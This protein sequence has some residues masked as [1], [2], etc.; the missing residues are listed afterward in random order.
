MHY[1]T[2]SSKC[3]RDICTASQ[4]G[5]LDGEN[6]LSLLS[7]R[8]KLTWALTRRKAVKMALSWQAVPMGTMPYRI[9]SCMAHYHPLLMSLSRSSSAAGSLCWSLLLWQPLT[10]GPRTKT[11]FDPRLPFWFHRHT[12]MHLNVF[13]SSTT[14]LLPFRYVGCCWCAFLR[15]QIFISPFFVRPAWSCYGEEW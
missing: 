5:A 6:Q 8:S 1:C 12:S 13:L 15:E 2:S 7:Q 14:R 9:T 10:K 11:K 4:G 3:I